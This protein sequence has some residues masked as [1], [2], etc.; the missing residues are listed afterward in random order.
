MPVKR[1][2]IKASRRLDEYKRQQLLLGPDS[3]LL[4]G[5][6][7]LTAATFDAM[8]EADQAQALAEMKRDWRA[9]REELLNWWN[10]GKDASH[11]GF[12]PWIFVM[13]QGPDTPPWA[14]EQFGLPG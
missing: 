11:Y 10:Q 5:V 4:A 3:E 8:S 1:S 12:K 13:P 9:N 7:Y 14:E 2:L 6:G